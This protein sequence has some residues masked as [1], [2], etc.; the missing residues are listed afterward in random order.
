MTD[1]HRGLMQSAAHQNLRT[2]CLIRTIPVIGLYV[3]VRYLVGQQGAELSWNFIYTLL[4]AFTLVILGSWWRSYRPAA[5]GQFEIFAHLLVDITLYSLLMFN[6]GGASNPFISY[7]LVPIAIAAITL[8]SLLTWVVGVLCLGAYSLLM[9][10]HIPLPSLAPAHNL[11]GAHGGGPNLHILG[12]WINFVVSGALIAY[13]V[14]RMATTLNKQEKSLS[15]QRQR[16]LEDDQLLAVATV[17]ASAAHDLGTPLNTMRLIIDDWPS[18]E[19]K[20]TID[21]FSEDLGIL[22]RQIDR[23]QKILQKLAQTARTFS[24]QKGN[25]IAA[26]SYFSELIE[27]WLLMRPDVQAIWTIDDSAPKIE[28]QLHPALAA[29]IHNLLNNAA[30]ASPHRVEIHITWDELQAQIFI[31]DHGE[32]ISVQSI[33]HHPLQSDKPSGMGL[34]LFLSRSILSRHGGDILLE[35]HPEGGTQAIIFL[36]FHRDND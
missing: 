22:R 8:S 13:F 18:F 16:Q 4:F 23:C 11:S 15:Q 5:I 20:N 30:D 19:T 35:K 2:L 7:F 28:I 10:W 14:N 6:L 17:A 27:R 31:R 25:A 21:H 12:M 24:T 3:G 34:G 32:G 9:F 29:S 26:K 1:H 33:P 36:P